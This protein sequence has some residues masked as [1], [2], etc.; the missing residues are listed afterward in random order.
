MASITSPI[1]TRFL[2]VLVTALTSTTAQDDPYFVYPEVFNDPERDAFY[3]G[4]FPDDFKWSTAT[5]SYQIEGAWN[6][7]GKGESIWDKFAHEGTH[8]ANGDT[9]DV[10]CDSYHKY[11]TDVSL[12]KEMG[13]SNYRFSLSWP[14][15]LPNGLPESASEDGL[16][17]YNALIDE[18]LANDINPQVTLYH[19]DLPQAL[20]DNGGFLSDSF[21]QWFNDYADYCFKSF[22]D[23]VKFWITFN[24]PWI[25]A[26][27]GYGDGV[28]A[29]GGR[30]IGD[31]VYIASHNLIKGHAMA[32]RT[33]DASYRQEQMG[34]VG[35][36]LNSDFIEPYNRSNPE[37]V[38]AASR[39][40][41]FGIGW[42]ANPI[43]KN[44]DYPDVMREKIDRKSDAQGLNQSRLPEF[45]ED[46]KRM[47]SGTSDFFG[48]NHY[49]TQYCAEPG[50]ED[51]S[52]PPSYYKD[53]DLAQWKDGNWPQTGSSWL[54]V[55][56][57]GIRRLV[58][59]I[60][61]E[62]GQD[63]PIYVTENGVSTKDISDLDDQIRIDYY[64]S[65]INEVLKAIR[66]DR[67]DVKGYTAWSL[68]DNFEWAA[69]YT[70]R[71]GLHY[72]DFTDPDR[73]RTQKNSAK[74]Y[75]KI[76][77]DNG[78][79]DA[80]ALKFLL[81]LVT[82]LTS[83][84]AQDD[85]YF[86]YPEVFNDPERDAFYYGKFPDDF[87]WSTATSS[88]QIE[89]AWNIN[90]K[91]ESIW[92]T[93]THEGSHVANNDTG[94]V[95]CDSYHKYET[96]VSLIKEMGVSNYRFSLS[97]PRLLPNGLPESAS[98]DGLRYYNALIDELLANDINPQVTLY[99]WDLPQALEDNGG[100]LSD[101]F[102]QWFNDYADYCFESFGDRV[103]FWITFNEPWII[104]V[105]GYGDGVFAP[106]GKGI[107]DD[108]YIASHNLIKGH[109]MAYRTYDTSYRQ[110]QMGEI[111]ITLNSDFVEPYDRS[112]QEDVEAASR[113]LRFGLGWYANPIFINGDYP[114]VM[115]EKI[116]RKSDA[117]GLNQS[118]LPEFTEDEKQ[119]ILGTSDF[120]GLNHYTTQYCAEPGTEDLS[121]PPSYYKD[122][123][124]VQ[125]KDEN[126]PKSGSSWLQVVP[127]GIRR[128]LVWIRDEYGQNVPIYVTENGISTRDVSDLDDQDR[129]NY[130][131]SY[132]NEVLKAIRIDEVDVRG[133]TA[134][135]LLDNF[136]WASGYTERFG[137]HYVDFTDPDRPRT[138][139]NSSMEYAKIVAD[140][141]FN[142]AAALTYRSIGGKLALHAPAIEEEDMVTNHTE[143]RVKARG[144]I[145]PIIK[146]GSK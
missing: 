3:Y 101:S 15:L 103:K 16:R 28:F 91:G 52:N 111:G 124:V 98:E 74:E 51:L 105:L 49:T 132:I 41:R 125:W 59:W 82:A 42:Y 118:R 99:H 8:V 106:G 32:Y 75:A 31:H 6:V 95:A 44:G 134:W 86:V 92:D 109:A 71:F 9:G 83:T 104:A 55:V 94:D 142:D 107:G 115:R 113:S 80:A 68:M 73:P 2:L 57:W 26:I 22:G 138:Q 133:Y 79:N 33:Y 54:Q 46:E 131:K 11:E 67:V 114:D 70:E 76:V 50:T 108:V 40:L 90:D 24:E 121:N 137:L 13:V 35:I 128:L 39:S 58:V 127:W 84:T 136:E 38:E 97:W 69:G 29:P 64:R 20:E 66:I 7:G 77:A 47:I 100:F 110:E 89:G 129:I 72:V 126:W 96:D 144:T 112:K 119:M 34:Q 14:R 135:S 18:L 139:K 17:Y 23:R 30:G 81:V 1:I 145:A 12:I 87:K 117:Q 25:I 19:W 116:D 130:Y 61:D 93:F 36:T 48:L 146:K 53:G 5:S 120:F 65:Y 141:G 78:F 56:P 60:R 122:G 21:P 88:Y 27:L 85:P 43:F 102:P 123:D 4:K 140:N 62:Y 37:D 45:T 63:V 10:A 143:E